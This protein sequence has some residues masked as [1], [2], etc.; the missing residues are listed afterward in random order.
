MDDITL[1]KY[2]LLHRET[3]LKV[4]VPQMQLQVLARGK[5]EDDILHLL[6]CISRIIAGVYKLKLMN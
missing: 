6:T 1:Y 5:K 2:S 4:Q 3:N